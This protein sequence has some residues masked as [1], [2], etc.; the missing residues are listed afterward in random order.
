VVRT[1]APVAF[2][3]G[4]LRPRICISTGLVDTLTNRELKAVLLHED[5]HRLHHDPLRGLVA[6]SVAMLLFFL[7]IAAEL[8]DLFL[9]SM[10]LDADRHAARLSGRPAL[11]GAILKIISHPLAAKSITAVA[12]V[13]GICPTDARIAQLTGDRSVNVHLSAYS[14]IASSAVIMLLCA[15]ARLL[16]L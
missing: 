2:C 7:P 12:G 10:E 9:T 4:Q 8:R 3:F 16:S 5:R 15:M 6:E 14:L 1:D 13:S 11:A